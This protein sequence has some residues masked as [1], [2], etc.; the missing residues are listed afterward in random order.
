MTRSRAEL[1]IELGHT[2]DELVEPRPHVEDHFDEPHRAP[3]AAQPT[4]RLAAVRIEPSDPG[5]VAFTRQR[6]EFDDATVRT[7]GEPARHPGA[8]GQVI[9]IR[10]GPI[11]VEVVAGSRRCAPVDLDPAV[12]FSNIF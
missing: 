3:V 10:A 7:G 9:V 6:R 4:S 12:H 11:G 1:L 2:I 8:L 5:L